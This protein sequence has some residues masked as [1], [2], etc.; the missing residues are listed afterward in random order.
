MLRDAGVD[1]T[2]P[3]PIQAAMDTFE[4]LLDELEEMA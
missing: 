4:K 1:M 3:Q 2:T